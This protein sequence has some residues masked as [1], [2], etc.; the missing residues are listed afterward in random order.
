MNSANIERNPNT[1]ISP[2]LPNHTWKMHHKFFQY[3]FVL[4]HFTFQLQL[5][6]TIIP[7]L[8]FT[9]SVSVCESLLLHVCS[10]RNPWSEYVTPFT[11]STLHVLTG[12]KL[13]TRPSAGD[14]WVTAVTLFISTSVK[15]CPP[16]TNSFKN[17]LQ[18]HS[19][20]YAKAVNYS[21]LS[22]LNLW[23]S[24]VRTC[25]VILHSHSDKH[26]RQQNTHSYINV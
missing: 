2:W 3:I 4:M 14:T 1:R 25:P 13:I 8:W 26:D 23:M 24:T 15:M 9:W 6:N 11:C 21:G 18:N 12:P 17:S 16:M 10:P 20:Y 5:Q 22:P 19:F 7:A